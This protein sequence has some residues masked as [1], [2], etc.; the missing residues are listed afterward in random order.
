MKHT[1][2]AI[3]VATAAFSSV[4]VPSQAAPTEPV[5]SA[6]TSNAGNVM[7]AYYYRGHYYPY[8]YHGHYYRYRY[9]G[10]Y[11]PYRY[12]G[13]YYRYRYGGRYCNQRYYR[14]G[15]YYCR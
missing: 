4:I 14:N 8:R 6:V 5:Q 2:I 9:H 11:Y 10:H 7:L 3:G 13:R 15:R 1:L 12:G